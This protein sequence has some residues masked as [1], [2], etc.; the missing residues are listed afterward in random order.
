VGGIRADYEGT[1]S[2]SN[3]EGVEGRCIYH[4]E[5]IDDI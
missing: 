3:I 2:F 5:Y 1:V 4:I